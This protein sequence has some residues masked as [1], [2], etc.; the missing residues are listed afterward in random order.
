MEGSRYVGS[1]LESSS[2]SS[3][4]ASRARSATQEPIALSVSS[5]NRLARTALRPVCSSSSNTRG[6]GGCSQQPVRRVR[7]FW[8]PAAHSTRGC[9]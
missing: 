8:V 7:V 1:A 5:S 6:A 9:R 2:P 3:F 4:F